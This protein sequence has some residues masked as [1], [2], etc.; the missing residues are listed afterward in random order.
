M[1]WEKTKEIIEEIR[2]R[3]EKDAYA[4]TLNKERQPGIFDSKFGGV[5][6]WDKS[7]EYPVDGDGKK[8][9]L[10]AQINFEQMFERVER[11]ELLP[12]KGILQFFIALDEVYGMEFEEQDE[13]K[14]FRVVYHE[15]VDCH[16]TREEVE[17]MDIPLSTSPEEEEYSPIWVE[18]ALEIRRTKVYMGDSDYRFEKLFQDI[19]SERLGEECQG[20]SLYQLL[21]DEAYDNMVEELGNENHW[22]L[23]YPYFTQSDPR[24]YEEKYRYYDTLLFQMDSDYGEEEDDILWGD[25]GVAN[26]FMNRE[27]L[28]NRNF[29]KVLY[30]WDCC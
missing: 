17:A 6:Y 5:P 18:A 14:S 1:N 9:M 8:M 2:K 7:K 26:F 24:E 22:L 30:N 20:Q 27:D 3:T 13:Q 10:L 4:L 21:D 25:A 11:D 28:K 15:N 19:V 29:D 23:G 12:K 16:V